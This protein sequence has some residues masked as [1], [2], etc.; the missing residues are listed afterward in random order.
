[1]PYKDPEKKK[2]NAKRRTE[3]AKI[4]RATDPEFAK[5]EK[6]ASRK[7]YLKRYESKDD[8][9][10]RNRN[11]KRVVARYGLTVEE[12]A[13]LLEKQ[14]YACA[15]CGTPHYDENGK[16]LSIDHNHAKGFKAVRGLLCANCNFGLGLFKDSPTILRAAAEYLEQ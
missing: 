5:K 15:I 1:M 9:Y 16:R 2:A 12:Y 14:G 3:R 4:R 10:K 6:E 8:T 11:A 13:K 7:W